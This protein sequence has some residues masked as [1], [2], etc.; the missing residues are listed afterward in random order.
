MKLL[1]T[2]LILAATGL[3]GWALF[4]YLG[5]YNI[6]ADE[7]HS[8]PAYWLMETVRERS[9]TVRA[10]DIQAPPLT[11][12]SLIASGGPDY[13]EMCS[14]CHLRPG[15]E[16]SELPTGLYPHPPN[17]TKVKRADPAETF[18]IIKHGIKMSG[19]AAWGPTHDDRRIWAMVAFLQQLPRLTPAQY[20]I[21]T[22]RIDGDEGDHDHGAAGKKG[23]MDDMPGMDKGPVEKVGGHDNHQ[24]GS[25]GNQV[26]N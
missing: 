4:V 16:E 14:E 3:A 18:W 2:L 8:R 22:A 11:D 20:Q 15:V 12:A 23:S 21:L 1:K 6:A 13:N 10:K 25:G 19:M 9:I 5:V 7:P 26:Q 24:H 17:L